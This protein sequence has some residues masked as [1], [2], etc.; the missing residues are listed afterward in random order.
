[1]SALWHSRF[2]NSWTST[3]HIIQQKPYGKTQSSTLTWSAWLWARCTHFVHLVQDMLM[4]ILVFDG[5]SRAGKR[6]SRLIDCSSW[7]IM[8]SVIDRVCYIRLLTE[9]I[10]LTSWYG[11]YLGYRVYISHVLSRISSTNW[12]SHF[13]PPFSHFA[14]VCGWFFGGPLTSNTLQV[15]APKKPLFETQGLITPTDTLPKF[16]M[17][18][19]K[20][21]P[22]K[23]GDSG[24][25]VAIAF[26]FHVFV[27]GG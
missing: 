1:M 3:V 5:K 6:N 15:V 4:C 22:W 14:P 23:F 2:E 24:L 16:N 20:M 13:S 9:E 21:T 7:N 12:T 27:W 10:H 17:V 19:L 11:E 18:H 8:M 25:G 26:R